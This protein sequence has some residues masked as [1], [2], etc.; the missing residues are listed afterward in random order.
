MLADRPARTGLTICGVAVGVSAAVAIQAA[1]T[2]VLHSFE[3]S[4]TTVAGRA[5]LQV[6]SGDVGLDEQIIGALRA[7][8]D[9]VGAFPVIS[10]EARTEDHARPGTTFAVMA[11]D[12][13]VYAEHIA[14]EIRNR[15]EPA[16]ALET[17]LAADSIFLGERL[18]GD[19]GL[20][21]GDA[22][23][24]GV[25]TVARR[26]RVRGILVPSRE[27]ASLWRDMAVMDIAA[28]Q[29]QFGL[30]GRLDRID[31]I[32]ATDR[33]VADVAAEL[34]K[35]VPPPAR[36]E[37]PSRRTEQVERMTRAFQLNV[38]ALSMV[39]LLISLLLVYNTVAYS[40]LQRRREI[41][42]V[43]ALGLTR[44]EVVAAFL[45]GAVVVGMFGGAIGYGLGALFA[46]G[47][48]GV[49][50]RTVSD[51]YAY[52]A[53]GAVDVG[54]GGW[55]MLGSVGLGIGVSVLG[56][57]GPSW[58]ASRAVP[59]RALLPVDYQAD[60][61]T[62][63]GRAAWAGGMLL[64]VAGLLALP[65]SVNG[66]PLFGY[67]SALCLLMGLACWI[68]LCVRALPACAWGWR[69]ARSERDLAMSLRRL[70]VEQAVHSGG[71]HTV[72][73]S[74]LMIGL[75]LMVGVSTM[76]GSFRG[77]VNEW[78]NQTVMADLIV[79][80]PSWLRGNEESAQAH[81]LPLAWGAA[82][83]TLPGVAAVDA[84]RQVR[85][86]FN[87]TPV[88]LVSRELRIHGERSRYLFMPGT[89]PDALA[90]AI[91][92]EGVLLSE[93]LASASG[94]R[95]GSRIA[96]MTPAGERRFPVTG[97]F[98]DY[99]TDGGK[100]VMD[101]SLYRK[102]WGEQVA[103]VF[104]VYVEPGID[105]QAV[106]RAI[107][108]R[109][110][111]E[112]RV[113]VISNADLKGDIL[114]I[115]DR[116]FTVTRMLEVIAVV[117]AMLGIVNTMFTAVWER[118]RELA[119][120]RALGVSGAGIGR[121]VLWESSY[122]GLVGALLGV[123]GGVLLSLVLVY[124]VN[125]Q[126]FGWTIQWALSKRALIEAVL[127]ALTAAVAAGYFPARLAARRCVVEDLRYE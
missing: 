123:V 119:M 48:F 51:L 29:H 71:R 50:R 112:G 115:F 89:P 124:V 31:L 105:T 38:A 60:S 15:G 39:G 12:L 43:R 6:T 24:I 37:R 54:Q 67:L 100:I 64:A 72:V 106:R 125:K 99:A 9:V 104:P 108:E 27:T 21:V 117:I 91:G 96:L 68:P 47:L 52:V 114:G 1:N 14:I 82:I 118:R 75:A 85:V 120:L 95:T 4:V 102:L 34:Q 97:V 55:W 65:S 121:L 19:L 122:L 58:T 57:F 44:N 73:V 46:N 18:A 126:S 23:E 3:E 62:R 69:R 66:V 111:P 88:S 33:S 2:E 98:Y 93:V 61:G 49:M 81:R 8:Q 84:Y 36:V 87:G 107:V 22:V 63:A 113:V 90:R 110:R 83:R 42:M 101:A 79:A 77:T 13:L 32:T 56:A 80:A 26:L 30:V 86:E 76:I 41:G 45:G 78:I 17:L 70:A 40:V 92:E 10:L 53:P 16:A 35:L 127:L 116:T 94:A 11:V 74:A 20:A 5:T 109:L 103:T 28:A 25:G 7:H 59:A